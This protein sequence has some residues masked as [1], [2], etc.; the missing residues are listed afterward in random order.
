MTFKLVGYSKIKMERV[1]FI[2]R[3]A[4]WCAMTK[5]WNETQVFSRNLLLL[6]FSN[7][8]F[9]KNSWATKKIIL[10]DQ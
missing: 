5:S 8:N 9:C 4:V 2:S 7:A 6:I 3:Y 10:L 1:F